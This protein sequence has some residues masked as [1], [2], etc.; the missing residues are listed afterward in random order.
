MKSLKKAFGFQLK[1]IRKSKKYTQEELA[2]M[3]DLSPRQL[4]RIENGDNF[5]SVDTLGKISTLLDVK[6][7]TLF[8]FN[9]GNE[10]ISLKKDIENDILYKIIKKNNLFNVKKGLINNFDSG[11]LPENITLEEAEN[12]LFCT[13]KK[14]N[15]PII[16]EFFE[17]EKPISIKRFN[18]D[19]KIE[20]ILSKNDILSEEY[21]RH[22]SSMLESIKYVPSKLYFI[23]LAVDSLDNKKFLKELKT[24]IRWIELKN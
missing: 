1:A 22:I 2:E 18:P 19:G 21:Y 16:S 11:E 13:A 6:L 5:P 23:K 9:W 24:L 17:N 8:D 15:K 14:Y 3:I 20:D 12:F 4:I 7:K 10:T